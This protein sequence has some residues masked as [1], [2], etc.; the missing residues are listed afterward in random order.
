MG[1]LEGFPELSNLDDKKYNELVDE[2]RILLARYGKDWTD[3]NVHDPGITFIEL[4]AWL[5]EMQVYQLN[6]VTDANYK[7]FLKLAGIYPA[8]VEPARV[9]I[10]FKDATNEI[11][12]GEKIFTEIGGEKIHFETEE[13]LV[14]TSAILKKILTDTNSQIIDNTS[15]N[16]K[17]EIYFAPF[18][19]K[20]SPGAKFKLGFNNPLK[21]KEIKITFVLFEEDIPAPESHVDEIAQ[22]ISSAKVIWEYY[23]GNEWKGFPLKRDT[24]LAFNRSG[25]IV[26]NGLTD[27]TEKDGLYWIQ[28]R[29]KEGNYEIVPLF[30]K[31]LLN[32][33]CAVQIERIN[34]D[35]ETGN[36]K[37]G[38]VVKLKN[39]PAI[40][41]KILSR[42]TPGSFASDATHSGV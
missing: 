13:N 8:D 34:E 11:K 36:R 28:C 16:E 17:D 29:L 19:E 24:T 25:R 40:R 21:E 5:A 33:I 26:F 23:T 32:T 30:N 39:N 31:I 41:E 3:H 18:G 27:M 7:K 14:P 22:V 4:F 12:A 9:D 35:F 20:I 10:S 6:R 2:A 38:Y 37:P 15:A 1:L 42:A